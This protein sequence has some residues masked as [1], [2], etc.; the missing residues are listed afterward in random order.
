MVAAR[1]RHKSLIYITATIEFIFNFRSLL[2]SFILTERTIVKTITE[3]QRL[4]S[5][6]AVTV[7]MKIHLRLLIFAISLPL[8]QGLTLDEHRCIH[9]EVGSN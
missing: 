1:P 8:F 5:A 7:A 3:P 9:D 6:L 2:R 4:K